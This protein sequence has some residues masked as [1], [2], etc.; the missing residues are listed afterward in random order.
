VYTIRRVR[1]GSS[2]GYSGQTGA[3]GTPDIQAAA[4][5]SIP[6]DTPAD[7]GHNGTCAFLLHA[8]ICAYGRSATVKKGETIRTDWQFDKN[9]RNFIYVLRAFLNRWAE[10]LYNKDKEKRGDD[11]MA[12]ISVWVMTFLILVGIG[13]MA[14]NMRRGK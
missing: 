3:G 1:N 12:S 4:E 13:S 2:A 8:S 11:K 5:H 7:T 9:G 6:V 14:A 10:V